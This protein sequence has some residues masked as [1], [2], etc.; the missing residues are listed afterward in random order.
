MTTSW[1]EA[2][3][4]PRDQFTG[5]VTGRRPLPGGGQLVTL[6][7]PGD[8]CEYADTGW[9]VQIRPDNTIP[10]KREADRTPKQFVNTM[11]ETAKQQIRDALAQQVESELKPGT[12]IRN[13]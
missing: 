12:E 3:Q 2:S 5:K 1:E 4:C 6:V 9:L 8:N 10:D 7:C 11:T 13:Y